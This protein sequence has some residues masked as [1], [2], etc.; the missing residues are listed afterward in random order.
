M[1]ITKSPVS[2]LNDEK[3]LGTPQR[4]AHRRFRTNR[5]VHAILI[6]FDVCNVAT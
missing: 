5:P 3:I 4:I 2:L 1:L 6:T